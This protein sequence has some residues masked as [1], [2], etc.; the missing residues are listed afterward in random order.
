MNDLIKNIEDGN[1]VIVPTDTVYGISCDATNKDAIEKVFIAKQREQKPL[2]VMVSNLEMLKRYVKDINDLEQK[3]I[4]KYWPNTLTILFKKNDNL[5]EEKTCGSEYVGIRM[6]DN[7]LLLDLMNKINKPI[8][9]TSANIS[10]SSVITN[11]SLIEPELKEHI[12]YIYD[13]GEKT[14][15]ASTLVKVEDG[16]I[17]ILRE[18]ILSS[19]IKED[20]K[21]YISE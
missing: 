6:P 12:S 19:K 16:K 15:V 13:D 2:I 8:I 18:G 11:T 3:L 5:L 17:K 1:L 14:N 4:D 20:F 9:S 7:K 10:G 21:D